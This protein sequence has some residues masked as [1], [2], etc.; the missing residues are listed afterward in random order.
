MRVRVEKK[1]SQKICI[2]EMGRAAKEKCKDTQRRH[3][4]SMKIVLKSLWCSG[5]S[6]QPSGRRRRRRRK[7]A[8]RERT[9]RKT[10][11]EKERDLQAD[12]S[13]VGALGE[14]LIIIYIRSCHPRPAEWTGT[15]RERER[16]SFTCKRMKR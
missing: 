9:L 6:K 4:A 5:S 10:E 12:I 7:G 2:K 8:G 3:K 11:R 14:H 13:E 1:D 15:Q 16:L